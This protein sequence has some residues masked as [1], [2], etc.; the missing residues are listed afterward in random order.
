MAD[1]NESLIGRI[2][3]GIHDA[4]YI[5]AKEMKTTVQD[6]GVLIFFILVPL[7]YPLLYSW[8]YNNETARDVPVA[9]VDLSHSQLS[10]QFIRQFD[11]SPDARVAYHCNNLEEAKDL[12]GHQ[13]VR[14]VILIPTDFDANINRM[15]QAHISLYCD[16]SFMLAY[17]AIY[18]TA[19]AVSSEI[20]SKI[21]IQVSGNYTSREDEIT[22]HP[23][24]FEEVPVFNPAGGYGSFIIPGVL[25]LI[26][27]Q[28]LVLGIGLSAGTARENNR[29]R[30]LV[31]VSR[32]YNGIFRIVL[33]KSLCYFMVYAVIAAYLTLVVPRLFNF[34]AFAHRGAL[35]ALMTPYVLACIFFGMFISCMVRYRENVLLLIVFMSIPLLFLSGVSW[36][37]SSIPGAWRAVAYL[38]PSTFGVRGYVRLSSMGATLHDIRPEY[39]MLWVHTVV[40]FFLTCLVYRFQ[41]NH[42]R[43]HAIEEID[44]MRER[45]SKAKEKT[46]D[47]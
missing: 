36:P 13:K 42:A 46:I 43:T 45:V 35:L 37:Q 30:D 34:T 32:H 47:N 11:A 44:K 18:M 10:R 14:G 3:E 5:W 24:A 12:V 26:I 9:V 33:G 20:N 27:Q 8:A 29:F 23:L 31:P 16:M 1:R 4:C 15:Q 39:V 38:F 21:Q 41:I 25:I 6:E 7:L 2:V 22:T 40:Y 17:K 28:T 19:M